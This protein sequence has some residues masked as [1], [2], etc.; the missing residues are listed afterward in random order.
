MP[1]N[2]R[3]SERENA[4][5]AALEGVKI[6]DMTTVF[7]GPLATQHLGDLGADV[8]KIESLE[9][10]STRYIG[11]GGDQGMGPLFL[12]LNRNKRSVAL[13]LKSEGG[14]AALLAIAEKADV[15]VY[16]VRPA[17]MKR[18]GLDY[19]QLA[20]V[21][22]SIVYAGL[23]GFSQKGRYAS[24][25]AF[26]DLIQAASGLSH[27]VGEALN[28]PPRYVPFTVADRSV[29]IY[30]FGI[31]AAAL[32]SRERTGR[33]QKIDIPMYET[34]L[35]QVLGDHLY[36][37]TFVPARAGMGYPRIMSAQRR[38]YA[39]EDG[40]I[41]CTVYTDQQWQ[42]F[43]ALTGKGNL[44]SS[45]P[46]FATIATRTEVIDSLYEMVA[47][48]LPKR[49]TR[50]WLDVL[51]QADIPCFP[52]QTLEGVLNDPHLG[53]VG[54]FE[55]VEH[56]AVGTIRQLKNPSEWSLTP[57]STRRL[58]PRL[59]E[60]TRTVLEEAGLPAEQIRDLVNKGFSA[61]RG[62]IPSVAA[63]SL[64]KSGGH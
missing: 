28:S 57:P 27:A 22:P 40:Y 41:C 43:L 29:G 1:A 61:E 58:A 45:D 2:T 20:R 35:S 5:P 37:E 60:H 46:R 21:N 15:L 48:E 6:L 8:L 19:E 26:D 25:A 30:A 64:Q 18:L 62:S 24:L 50:E 44:F 9:G 49:R 14:R 52:V 7:M 33:G 47:A 11:P 38:P 59:G 56:P 10:D 31:I 12:N 4:P 36:G 32:Y 54:F 39:T 23:V 63:T 42:S 34:M 13:D 16:N 51:A 17:A 3:V 53:D 55:Q